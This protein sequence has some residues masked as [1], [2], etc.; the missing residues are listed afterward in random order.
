MFLGLYLKW[1][2]IP[3]SIYFQLSCSPNKDAAAE[4]MDQSRNRPSRPRLRSHGNSARVLVFE[5]ETEETACNVETEAHKCPTLPKVESKEAPVRPGQYK[6]LFYSL[7][8]I[9]F[10]SVYLLCFYETISFV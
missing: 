1:L 9:S 4:V 8:Y 2:Q 10:D 5:N 6:I 7:I 3:M